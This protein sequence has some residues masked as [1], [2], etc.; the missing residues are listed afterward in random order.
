[1]HYSGYYCNKSRSNILITDTKFY[2]P[3][4]TLSTQDNTKL[5]KQ[6]KSG[7]RITI[8][9]NKYQSKKSIERPNHYL[10]Y[11]IDPGFQGVNRL[12]VLS[13]QNEAQRASYKGHYLPTVEIKRL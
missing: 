4:V 6:L 5:H 3:A 1:M 12:F 11:W 2:A 13:F 9:W 7:F 10:D 8:N